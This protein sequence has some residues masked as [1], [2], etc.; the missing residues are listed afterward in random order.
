MKCM[1]PRPGL[2]QP[3]KSGRLYPILLWAA[4]LLRRAALFSSFTL[5]R[6]APTLVMTLGLRGTWKTRLTGWP[7]IGGGTE[8][9][10][11]EK[12]LNKPSI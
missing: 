11:R 6:M 3:E 10:L 1:H 12:N 7:K 2:R 4:T 8:G 5:T 9:F